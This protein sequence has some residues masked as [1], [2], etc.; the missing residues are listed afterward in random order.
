MAHHGLQQPYYAPQPGYPPPAPPTKERKRFGW[1][2]LIFVGFMCFLLGVG[3]GAMGAPSSSSSSSAPSVPTLTPATGGDAPA[4]TQAAAEPAQTVE[5][6]T[7]PLGEWLVPSEVAPGRYRSG[8]VEEGLLEYCQVTTHDAKGNVLEWKNV[9]G[10]GE[11][12]MVIVS[13]NAVSVDNSG[14]ATFTK[15]D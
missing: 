2:A 9:G 1:G 6:G 13:E 10:A 8:G 7:I 12:L 15:V 14:C 4:E 5:A 11:S 3:C